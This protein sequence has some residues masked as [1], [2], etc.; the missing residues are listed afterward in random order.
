[1]KSK[2]P[3]LVFALLFGVI[4]LSQAQGISMGG[5]SGSSSSDSTEHFKFMPLPYIN[6][7]RSLEFQI[8]FLPMAMYT[9]NKKD[10]VS[11]QSVSGLIGIWTTNKSWFGIGFSKF[12]LKEDTWRLSAAGGLVSVNFQTYV[13][14]PGGGFVDYNTAADFV[15][16]QA[17]RRLVGKLFLGVHY[18]YFAFNSR[19]EGLDEPKVA[20]QNGVG[21]IL[22]RDS[23]DDVYYP[24]SGGESEIDW[25]S[26]PAFLNETGTVNKAELS[27]NHFISVREKNDIIALRGYVGFGLGEPLIFEQQFIVGQTDIRGYTQGKYRGNAIYSVQ[28]EYRWNLAERFGLVGFFG[29]ATISGAINEADNGVFL[30]GVGAGFR[31]TAFE[32]NHFNIGLDAAVGRDDWGLYFRIGEAF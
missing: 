9:L 22:S 8:G 21:V 24:R 26:F 13:D 30:P 28:G 19:F 10:T 17:Q 11:P 32:K 20:Y 27:H 18:N 2:I 3:G 1:M 16:V 7:D 14:I 12:F 6:Y 5:S 15:F 31:Y 29:M 4:Q 25:T 23:R